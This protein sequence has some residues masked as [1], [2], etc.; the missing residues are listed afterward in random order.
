MKSKIILLIPAIISF[1]NT[2]LANPDPPEKD[3]RTIFMSRCATCHNVNKVLT[4]P[5]LAG[6]DERRSIDWI[7]NFVRSSQSMVKQGDKDAVALF[8]KF[9]KIPMPDHP[10]LTSESIKNIVAFIKSESKTVTASDAP[11]ANP[12]SIKAN[13]SSLSLKKNFWPV[14]GLLGAILLLIATILFALKVNNMKKELAGKKLV[15]EHR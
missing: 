14:A 13:Y 7:I 15:N 11:F 6:V 9:N 1:A 8:E 5:A 4:G 2:V 3:G 12:S 10:D